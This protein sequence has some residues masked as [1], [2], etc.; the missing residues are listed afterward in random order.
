MAKAHTSNL[1]T[2]IGILVALLLLAGV[3]FWIF[4]WPSLNQTSSAP[5][6]TKDDDTTKTDDETGKPVVDTL[7]SVKGEVIKVSQLQS[8]ATITSPLSITGE[9]PGNWSH[10]AVFTISLAYGGEDLI[11]IGETS[12]TV[13]G[14]WMTDSLRPFSATLE[15]TVPEGVSE[16]ML[17]I[18]NANPSGL[19]ENDDSVSIPVK[20]QS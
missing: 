16:G 18:R 17:I 1:V 10:E 2:Q 5:A 13:E 7:T 14:D 20:L 19:P 6:S 12:A 11:T 15:F 4:I 3:L 9:V 8:G